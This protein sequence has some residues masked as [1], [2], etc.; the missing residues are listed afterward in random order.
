MLGLPVIVHLMADACRGTLSRRDLVAAGFS[1]TTIDRWVAAGLLERVDRGEYRI[2][3]SGHAETQRLASRLWR[4][5]PGA[6]LAGALACGL[7]GLD[8]FSSDEDHYIAI[9]D[10]RHARGVTF[11]VVRTPVPPDDHALIRG[12]PGVS[13]ERALIGAAATH[14][15]ARVRGAYYNAKFRG[16]TT[17][18]AVV[19]RAVALGRVH[20]APQMRR[21]LGAG[22]GKVESPREFDLALI[23]RAGERPSEQVWVEWH[24]KWFRL[25][26]AYL[27]ARLSIEYDGKDHEHRREKDAD[28][29]LALAELQI[30]TIRVTNAMLADPHELRRRIL[31][32]RDQR[33]ALRLPPLVPGTPF[34]LTK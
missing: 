10:Y 18:A 34:W 21:I 26:F 17:E 19:E 1:T 31:T 20:G 33:L 11:S 29:D 12:L 16:L 3:G 32:V 28:R 14:R 27:A 9:P 5:G 13:V 30:E 2:P 24:G 22:A 7:Y 15:P 4:A 25:D 8:G 6:R 23:L